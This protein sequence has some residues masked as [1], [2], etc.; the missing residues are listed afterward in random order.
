MEQ[1]SSVMSV[2]KMALRKEF[3]IA[4]PRFWL[5]TSDLKFSTR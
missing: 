2:I 4:S 3:A 5:A 1:T